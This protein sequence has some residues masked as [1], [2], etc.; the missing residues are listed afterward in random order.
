ML[1]LFILCTA[2]FWQVAALADEAM[3]KALNNTLDN[4]HLAAAE[5]DYDEYFNLLAE[6]S[7][8]LGTDASERWT[9]AAFK[10]FVKPYF[11]QGKGWRYESSH[12][13]ISKVKGENI[14]FFDELLNNDSYGQC[15]GS[16]VLIKENN[17]WKIL[18]YNLSI[19][20]PNKLSKH[21]VSIINN[22]DEINQKP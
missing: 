11:S 17:Q 20:V 22:A 7:V 19:P 15:R 2:L 14:F 6:D 18:Q 9:K 1:K 16:G 8:F 5:A 10:K 13:Y 4:F 3:D 21:I 12:R